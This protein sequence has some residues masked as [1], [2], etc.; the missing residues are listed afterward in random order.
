[1][2][3]ICND[4]NLGRTQESSRWGGDSDIC[5]LGRITKQVA[6]DTMTEDGRTVIGRNDGQDASCVCTEM[7]SG[8]ADIGTLSLSARRC[9]RFAVRDTLRQQGWPICRALKV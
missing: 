5:L 2:S 9:D 4:N 8:V 3:S 1:M 6:R 7:N